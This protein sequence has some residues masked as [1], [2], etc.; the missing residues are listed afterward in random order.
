MSLPVLPDCR[1][2]PRIL[3]TPVDPT[4][5]FFP[6]TI[7]MYSITVILSMTKET[8]LHGTHVSLAIRRLIESLVTKETHIFAAENDSKSGYRE[9]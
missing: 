2:V 3:R 4:Y 7:T 5:E 8:L 1:A 6:R 9:E